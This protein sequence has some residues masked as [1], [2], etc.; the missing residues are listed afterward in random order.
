MEVDMKTTLII[1]IVIAVI[2]TAGAGVG[3]FFAGKAYERNHANSVRNDFFTSRGIQNFNP[4]DATNGGQNGANPG[5]RA[6]GGG[7]FGTVKSIDGNTL[8]L[9]TNQSDVTVTL[10]DTTRIEKTTDVSTADL[11]VGQNVTVAGQRDSNGNVTAS[12]V[13]IIPADSNLVPSGVTP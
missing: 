7:A 12:Q 6:F 9:T 10:S 8:V 13:T 5:A 4:N 2:V 3:G 1:V 11:Q